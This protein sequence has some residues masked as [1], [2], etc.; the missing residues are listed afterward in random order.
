[1]NETNKLPDIRE[2]LFGDM[3][4]SAWAGQNRSDRA[5]PWACFARVREDLEAGR[6]TQAIKQ[7]QEIT[8]GAGLETR[9]YL[10]AWHFLRQLGETPPA[11]AAKQVLGVVVEVGMDDGEDLLAAYADRSARYYNYSGAAII[12][13]HP[14][15][16]LDRMIAELLEAGMRIIHQ[17]G[18]WERTRPGPPASGEARVNLLTPSGLH[19][20]QAPYALL[21]KDAMGG[22]ILQAA[23]NLM[24]ALIEKSEQASA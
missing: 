8:A 21:A 16:S 10:Q 20:G 2:T 14:D 7:L 24:K 5:E 15:D 23:L 19:F 17:I 13:E 6:T 11:S 18:P 9:H 4:L 3:S 12:W 22:P 1:M